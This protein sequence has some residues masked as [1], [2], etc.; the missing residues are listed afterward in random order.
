MQS[1][2][3]FKVTIVSVGALFL[4]FSGIDLYIT[5]KTENKNT[6]AIEVLSDKITT[7][8][9]NNNS[10]LAKID[11]SVLKFGL[12]ISGDSVIRINPTFVN[13]PVT[14]VSSKDQKGGQ[15]AGTIINH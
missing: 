6:K 10:T 12:K 1:S 2:K 8:Q 13:N 4:I 5:S 3:Y 14:N 11:S 9:K 15:T 7:I